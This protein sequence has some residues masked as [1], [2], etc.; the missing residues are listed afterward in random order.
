MVSITSLLLAS[1]GNSAAI[2]K[3]KLSARV[4]Y[5][6]RPRLAAR[7]ATSDSL[8][9]L[10]RDFSTCAYVTV[11]SNQGEKAG[12]IILGIGFLTLPIECPIDEGP[13]A[14][15]SPSRRKEP[16]VRDTFAFR[17]FFCRSYLPAIFT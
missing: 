10:F 9:P 8:L 16:R 13:V 17:D 6:K 11:L 7:F 2:E 14:V 4:L 12:K 3:G 1:N 15:V 5:S